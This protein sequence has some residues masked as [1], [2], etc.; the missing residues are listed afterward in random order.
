VSDGHL[1]ECCYHDYHNRGLQQVIID[2][3]H[4]PA[5]NKACHI[6][7][8]AVSMGTCLGL[9]Y[10]NFYDVGVSKAVAKLWSL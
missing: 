8:Y 3:V 2:Y 5:M 1:L 9:M 6:L 4:G 7:L 10:L